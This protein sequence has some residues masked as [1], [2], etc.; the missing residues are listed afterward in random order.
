MAAGSI[1]ISLLMRTGAFETDTDRARKSLAKFEKQAIQTGKV[2]GTALGVG[3][4]A[5]AALFNSLAT[6]AA[7]FKDLEETTGASAE[8]IASFAVSAATA[9]VQVE[10]VAGSMNKLTKNLVGVDDESKAAGAALKALGLNVDDFKRLD[11]A[12]QYEAIGKAINGFSD[13]ATSGAAKV[14]I[15]M[16]LFGKSGAEQ[17]K[18][19]KALDEAGGR[20]VILTQ[21][22]IELA[23]AYADAQ[24]RSL[25]ELR[26]YAQAAA[27]QLLPALNDLTTAVTS[28]IK[29]LL[30]L[31][32]AGKQISSDNAI[33]SFADGAADAFAF[34]A[35]AGLAAVRVLSAVAGSVKSVGAD[36]VFLGKARQFSLLP[37]TDNWQ[38]LKDSFAER[39]RIAAESNQKYLDILEKD[40]AKFRNALG[41][42]R[43]ARGG[44]RRPANEGGGGLRSRNLPALS[45]AGVVKD[46][47][48]AK[49]AV[50]E[51]QKYLEA[52]VKQRDALRELTT[53]ETVLKDIQDGRLAGSS[54]AQR[55]FIIA[56]AGEIDAGK[57]LNR[58]VQERAAFRKADYEAA[59]DAA[60]ANAQADSDRLKSLLAN[61][62]T[63]QFDARQANLIVLQNALSSGR[64]EAK[65][66]GEAVRDLFNIVEDDGPKAVDIVKELGAS[67]SSAFE[68]AI[69]DG[70]KL[71]TVL[72]ALEKDILRIV[73]RKLVT[74]PLAGGLTDFLKAGLPAIGSFFGGGGGFT[75][76]DQ[77][78]NVGPPQFARG[79][80]YVPYDGFMA[81]LHKGERIQTAADAGFE[82]RNGA[83]GAGRSQVNNITISVPGNT[84]RSTAQQIGAEL[85]RRLSIANTRNN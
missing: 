84:S 31:D 69:V 32:K 11:P 12:A 20:Q 70:E 65:Q 52:L 78:P 9:G 62:E 74:E 83:E 75:Y 6:G 35:D 5:A 42:A 45:F 71:S 57:E 3:A 55:D 43:E 33:K 48:S 24:A 49:K 17:L 47:G 77:L 38:E 46:D 2:I 58:V 25:A 44:G 26:L 1:V 56:L 22:Q 40:A 54:A 13:D 29:E 41:A 73:T 85:T 81:S 79:L 60:R 53:V 67:F 82:R 7:E 19:F 61:T 14:A 18:V 36:I 63:A 21:Q 16:A 8:N 4:V 66:Y 39:N 28:V 37:T 64:I 51:A 10:S 27:T 23:D 59:E 30:G 72:Q 80:D 34:I 76:G 15:S 68:D 50:D